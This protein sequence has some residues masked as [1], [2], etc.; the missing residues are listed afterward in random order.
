MNVLE[1]RMYDKNEK[2]I[3][4]FSDSEIEIIG[5]QTAELD[6]G[7]IVEQYLYNFVNYIPENGLP[8]AS[9]KENIVNFSVD[10]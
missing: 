6:D 9:L 10:K 4:L 2:G 1:V 5:E 7:R 3:S 8:F